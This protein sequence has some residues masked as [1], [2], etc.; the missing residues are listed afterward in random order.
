MNEHTLQYVASTLVEL[1]R[2]VPRDQQPLLVYLIGMAAIE[3]G[4]GGQPVTNR[5]VTGG[6]RM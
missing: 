3:A 5:K 1:A 2:P 4:A 6:R